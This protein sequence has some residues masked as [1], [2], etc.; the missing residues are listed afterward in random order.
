M[1]NQYIAVVDGSLAKAIR[2]L[3]LTDRRVLVAVS[4]GPDSLC[5]LV[6]LTRLGVGLEAAHIDHGLR[7]GSSSE[8]ALVAAHCRRL[9]VPFHSRRLSIGSTTGVEAAARDARYAALE[10]IRAARGLDVVAT[11]HTASDQ[12]ETVL[13][14][15]SRGAAL[16]GAG[17]ILERRADRVVRPLLGVTRQETRAYVEVLGLAMVHDPMNDDLTFTRVRVRREVMPRLVAAVGLGAERA[18]ARFARLAQE[19]ESLLVDLART[20]H[21]RAMLADGSLDRVALM[22]FQRPVQRRVLAMFLEHA[23]IP[24][25]ATL[26]DDCLGSIEAGGSAT[27]PLDCL[28]ITRGGRVNIEPAPTRRALG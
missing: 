23:S 14:R 10:I 3:R 13:M 20:A 26:I 21:A 4:G 9:G 11:G 6:G 27:L 15:L 19:D 17:G 25:D 8:G 1:K 22:S 7:E 24:L 5:L 18:L 16:S 12:A 2:K 28:L